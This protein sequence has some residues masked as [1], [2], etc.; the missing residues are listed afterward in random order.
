MFEKWKHCFH[1]LS[2]SSSSR[3]QP[4]EKSCDCYHKI[5][6]L[7]KF[8]WLRVLN[9]H[10]LFKYMKFVLRRKHFLT[11]VAV[12]TITCETV[13]IS[14]NPWMCQK[15]TAAKKVTLRDAK[16]NVDN[17]VARYKDQQQI[18]ANNFVHHGGRACESQTRYFLD[19]QRNVWEFALPC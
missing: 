18:M 11:D 8:W 16:E 14:W 9:Q 2:R 3:V 7:K 15:G 6:P 13:Q 12:V 5:W 4:R 1:G 17:S 19:L 10:F